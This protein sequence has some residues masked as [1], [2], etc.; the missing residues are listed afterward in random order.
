MI[1]NLSYVDELSTT[2]AETISGGFRATWGNAK[3]DVIS[4]DKVQRDWTVTWVRTKAGGGRD[5]YTY[6]AKRL[7][8]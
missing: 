8:K 1:T 7:P 3:Y 2:E 5:I 4:S 6:S